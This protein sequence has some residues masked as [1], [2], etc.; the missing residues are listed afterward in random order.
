MGSNNQP[1]N[2]NAQIFHRKRR[3]L[4]KITDYVNITLSYWLDYFS[5]DWKSSG[6]TSGSKIAKQES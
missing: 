4:L 6:L 5:K 3:A 1:K 2:M